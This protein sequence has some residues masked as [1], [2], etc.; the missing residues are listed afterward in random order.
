MKRKLYYIS[1]ILVFLSFSCSEDFIQTPQNGVEDLDNYFSSLE[2]CEAFVGSLY[3]GF[4]R[5]D[6]WWQNYLRLNNEMATDDAWMGNLNQDASGNYPFA[7]YTIAAGNDPG[8]LINFYYFKYQNLNAANL[9][10]E[11]IPDAPIEDQKKNYLIGQAM[12]FRAYSHWELVQNFGDV[13]L[14]M[15]TRGSDQLDVDRSPKANVYAAMVSDLKSAALLLP[16]SWDSE[17]TGR[18]TSGACKALLARTYLFMKDYQNA[19][20]YADTVINSGNYSLEPEFVNIWSCYNHNGVESIFEIQT[21]GDQTYYVGNRVSVVQNARGEIWPANETDKAMDG[22]G[23][24]VP[25]SNL[26]NAYKSEADSIRLKSTIIRLGMPVYGDSAD[27]PHYQFNPDFNKSCRTWRKT[28]VP[29]AV[30]KTLTTKDSHIPLDMI[31]IRL[32]EMYLT[33]AE[34]AYFLGNNDQALSDINDIR[35]R[36]DLEPK[37]GLS[38][39]DLLYAIWKERRLEL[40]G[41]GMRLYDIRRQ[42]DPVANKPMVCV[43]MGANGTFVQYNATSTDYWEKLHTKEPSNKG[44]AFVEGRHELWPIPQAEID[45]SSSL[46]Q[47]PGY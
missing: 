37:N 46:S 38:G 25:T 39:N 17:N 41:E 43:L 32:A 12:F 31:L 47:N 19:F 1:L 6:D 27:N 16:D 7:F 5:W 2:E 42:I 18:V 24:C 29:I 13:V 15:A 20:A 30:R 45:K 14:S 40:A 3:K 10:I 9:A 33:R 28:Y 26:E 22:W 34:A 36:V 35:A 21:S 44:V 4:A 8:S 11:R 23:W